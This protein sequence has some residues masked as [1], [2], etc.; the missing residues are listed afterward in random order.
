MR[1]VAVS[2]GHGVSSRC[3]STRQSFASTTA[4]GVAHGPIGRMPS[5]LARA[6]FVPLAGDPKDVHHPDRKPEDRPTSTIAQ[7]PVPH[8]RSSPTPANGGNA[9]SSPTVVTREA[10]SIPT[11]KSERRSGGARTT[12]HVPGPSRGGYDTSCRTG[13]R[14]RG[15][16]R[17]SWGFTEARPFQMETLYTLPDPRCQ[18]PDLPLREIFHKV[19][20][21]N[22]RMICEFN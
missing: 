19:E 10:H 17:P 15:I 13:R 14:E 5:G 9:N 18:L 21:H 7:G 3:G 1:A 6:A 11:D 8:Q 20:K 22:T 12:S 4:P 2:F 16:S